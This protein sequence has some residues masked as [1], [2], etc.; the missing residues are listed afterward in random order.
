MSLP[1]PLLAAEL[2]AI[3]GIRHGFFTREGGVSSGLY[4][5][6]NCGLG[7]G[8]VRA[9]VLDNRARVTRALGARHLV[10]LYQAH[11]PTALVVEGPVDQADLPKADAV[12]TA[13]PGLAVGVLAADCA[14]ILFC[15]PAAKVVAAAHAGWRGAVGGII[16]ATVGAM[17]A[18]GAEPRRI[19]AAVGP[20]ISAASYEIGPDFEAEV[21][22][23]DA[24]ASAFLTEPQAGGKRHFDL[25]GYVAARLARA[26]VGTVGGQSPCTYATESLFS[27][28]RSQR[29]HEKDYGRQIS[30][31]VVA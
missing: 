10:T 20:C 6:L 23:A 5:S 28:R 18:I 25:P 13:T 31:I 27:Y 2:S 19:I 3:P 7:S 8:D 4:A 26:G 15:D 14:P 9:K 30:A 29:R 22:K 11:T 21:D 17:R 16:E 12:V 1:L 24:A